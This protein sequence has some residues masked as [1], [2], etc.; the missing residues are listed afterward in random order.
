[1]NIA[2]IGCGYWGPNLLRTFNNLQD[3]DVKYLVERERT[4]MDFVQ[5]KYPKVIVKSKLSE[6]LS[7]STVN[8]VVIATPAETHY[9]LA[10]QCLEAGKHILVEKPLTTKVCEIDSLEK[11]CELSKAQSNERSYIYLQ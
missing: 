8:A 2:Q 7:D 10:K 5:K 4:R 9:D 6:V 1:M 3:C 11:N